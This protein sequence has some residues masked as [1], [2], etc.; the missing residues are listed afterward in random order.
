MRFIFT[1]EV[2]LER[3]EGKFATRDE[4][5][6]QIQEELEGLNP[7]SYEGDEGGTYEVVNWEVSPDNDALDDAKAAAKKARAA[8]RKAKAQ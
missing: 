8:R 6:M 2:E 5:E 3:T 7:S 4:L 1:V